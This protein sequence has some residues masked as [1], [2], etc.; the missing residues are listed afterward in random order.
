[1]NI[2]I[3]YIHNNLSITKD[4]KYLSDTY[5]ELNNLELLIVDSIIKAK[6]N[7]KIRVNI[8]L[9]IEEQT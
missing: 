7:S 5:N 3:N 8:S 2:K 9:V 1:M 6:Q 4:I